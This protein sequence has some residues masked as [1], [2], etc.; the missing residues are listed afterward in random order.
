MSPACVRRSRP[1]AS[2]PATRAWSS[3]R[4][5]AAP[6]PAAASS[7]PSA[8]RVF[9]HCIWRALRETGAPAFVSRGRAMA[10]KVFI[11]GEAG[12]TGLEIRARLDG[13]RDLELIRLDAERRKDRDA[14]AEA[15]N[16][17]D[18]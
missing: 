9:P 3:G 13:R 11:D 12:T 16:A 8:D 14:R 1:R 6:R 10:H 18:A 17:A 2:S 7:S 15:L 5:T 4:S